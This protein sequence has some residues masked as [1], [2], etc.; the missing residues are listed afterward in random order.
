M[1]P[2]RLSGMPSNEASSILVDNRAVVGCRCV[3]LVAGGGIVRDNGY[4]SYLTLI[5][6]SVLSCLRASGARRSSA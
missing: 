6:F 4:L 3:V 5:F 1:G 2:A